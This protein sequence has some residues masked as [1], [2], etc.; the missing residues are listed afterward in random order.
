MFMNTITV[1]LYFLYGFR[2]R[3]NKYFPSRPNFATEV[4][5]DEVLEVGFS[6]FLQISPKITVE[7]FHIE[8]GINN[9]L[10]RSSK[11]A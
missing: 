9:S 2:V 8:F 1:L 3:E 4:Y 5:F 11:F 6:L 10:F 7:S